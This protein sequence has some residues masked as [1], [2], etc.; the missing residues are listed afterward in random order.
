MEVKVGI[1]DYAVAKKTG[2]ISTYGLGSCV[3]ITLYDR[4]N[5]VG[6]LL[7]ALL[8]E[9]ARYGGRG[10]PAKYVDT[11][12][13]LLIKDMMKLGASPR[14]LEAKLFGGAHMFTNVSNEN[15]MVG[16][17]NVEVAKRELKKRGIRLVAEDTG[18]KGGRTI[19]LDVSTGKVRMRKV[20]NGKVIEAVF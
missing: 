6:G 1:G 9:S 14:R 8:P 12:L 16:K 20:S 2:I 7:H 18:G 10:N 15:L 11:G 19:Y 13:E 4:L 5:R 3:G 17:K